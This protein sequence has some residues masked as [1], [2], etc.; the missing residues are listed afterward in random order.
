MTVKHIYNKVLL[1]CI[2]ML[3]KVTHKPVQLI[4][5]QQDK[6]GMKVLTK[7]CQMWDLNT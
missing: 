6:V 1:Y 5:L 4:W 3:S 2:L 7:P